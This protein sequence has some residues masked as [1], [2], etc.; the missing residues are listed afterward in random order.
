MFYLQLSWKKNTASNVFNMLLKYEIVI[1]YLMVLSLNNS[2]TV[3]VSYTNNL[4]VV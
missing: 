3:V 1:I 2:K 4:T